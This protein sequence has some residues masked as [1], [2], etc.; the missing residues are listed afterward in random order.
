MKVAINDVHPPL[1]Y[2][3]LYPILGILKMANVG[4]IIYAL[5]IVSI[6]PYF[7]ILCFSYFKLK[8]EYNWLTA[9]LFAFAILVMGDFFIQF[10]TLRM[11][12]WG[13]LFLLLSFVYYREVL[14]KNDR[15][16]WMLLTLFTLL[17]AYTHYFLILTSGLIYICF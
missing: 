7:I 16:S 6:I 10:L 12:S 17:C 9:G 13:L 8:D 4:N 2:L 3:M 11:Y 15:K 14:N 5:K 1:Y